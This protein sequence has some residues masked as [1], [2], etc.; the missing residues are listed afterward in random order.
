[1]NWFVV[2]AGLLY[3]GGAVM[4]FNR[5]AYDMCGAFVA[6]AVA[7]FFLARMG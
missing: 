4:Y 2:I 7:N 1:V 3:V 6:Y 5:G